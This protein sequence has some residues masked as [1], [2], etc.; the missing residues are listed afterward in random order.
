MD[1]NTKDLDDFNIPLILTDEITIQSNKDIEILKIKNLIKLKYLNNIKKLPLNDQNYLNKNFDSIKDEVKKIECDI[2]E[3]TISI[4]QS[5]K[6]QEI[7]LKKLFNEKELLNKN[8]IQSDIINNQQ[9]LIDNYKKNN[10]KLKLNLD[11][12]E[13]TLEKE[14]SFSKN[15]LINNEELKTTINRYIIHNKQLQNNIN[16]LKKDYLEAS[17]SKSQ[18]NEMIVKIKFYQEENTRLSSELASIQKD[19]EITKNNL[20]NVENE[21]NNIYNQIKELNNS[22]NESKTIPLIFELKNNNNDSKNSDKLININN[23]KPQKIKAPSASEK[24]LDDQI[25]DIFN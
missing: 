13:K 18:I 5:I 7:E 24:D 25:N 15:F 1:D 11:Q 8:K 14:I 21:K 3:K 4:N 19:Y 23:K 20:T 12:V 17:F 6:I 10:I 22:L 9:K 2:R 16:Q